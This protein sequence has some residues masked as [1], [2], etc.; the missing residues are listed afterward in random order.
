M[1]S[2]RSRQLASAYAGATR[3]WPA[4]PLRDLQAVDAPGL[5]PRGTS[6]RVAWLKRGDGLGNKLVNGDRTGIGAAVGVTIVT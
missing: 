6:R 1:H 5:R 3:P 2:L 4:T